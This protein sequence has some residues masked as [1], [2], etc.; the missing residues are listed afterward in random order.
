MLRQFSLYLILPLS[1]TLFA[2]ANSSE[3]EIQKALENIS[4]IKV[5]QSSAPKKVVSEVKA[6][7]SVVEPEVK[8]EVLTSQPTTEEKTTTTVKKKKLHKK[9][10]YKKRV[11]KKRIHRKK[12]VKADNDIDVSQLKDAETLGVVSTS[13][14]FILK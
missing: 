7:K 12:P 8:K 1:L 13:K 2:S 11:H 14:P 10:V 9:K 6:V 3:D 4:Q 5:M